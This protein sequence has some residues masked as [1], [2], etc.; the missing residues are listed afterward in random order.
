MHSYR[1]LLLALTSILCA[2]MPAVRAQH[3]API[4]S[5]I[6]WYDR[7]GHT[8][9]A[10]GGGILKDK[11]KYYLFGEYK[12]DSSNVFNGF[13]CYSSAD[14]S[15][16]TFECIALP[17]QPTGAL[18]PNRVGERPKVM[19][20]PATGEY[21]MLMHVDSVNYKDQYVGYATSSTVNGQYHF[22]GPLLFDGKPI[23]KWDI[24]VFQD[25][26][27]RG[28]LITHSGNLYRLS[29]DFHSVEEQIVKDMTPHCEAPV[30][31]RKNGFYFWLG[32][33]LTSWERN[34]NYYF[35]AT[36]LRGPWTAHGHFA[37]KGSLTWNSQ[38]TFVLPIEGPTDT[39]L[40]FMGD[41][42]AFPRQHTAATYLWLP[43]QIKADTL[44]LPRY[45]QCWQPDLQSGRWHETSLPG[46]TPATTPALT[47]QW[48]T[49]TAPD[50]QIQYAS[51]QKGDQLTLP[52]RGTRIGF[53]G[54]ASPQGGY[55]RICITNRKGEVLLR[56]GIDC[57]CNYPDYSL[58]FLSPVLPGGNYLM[59]VTVEGAHGVWRNKRGDLF[60]S[61][62]YE[63][64]LG[65]IVI[66]H[67]KSYNPTAKSTRLE[68]E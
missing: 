38:S 20:C 37:P 24:G 19:R 64:C 2:P 17:V 68:A 32:S 62:G 49:E 41:R 31:F 40:I 29:N 67:D 27:G 23:R 65:K 35:T 3:T 56:T 9:S 45:L 52:F 34:D 50:G 63:V 43:L 10:H 39:T 44:L 46:R 48:K 33:E 4:V 18:G 15:H 61:K 11:G 54:K 53:Y 30:L 28:Y 66:Q 42:W 14:L 13:S 5:G 6:P 8:V 1:L 58:R 25:K 60:G 12:S 16:W 22:R 36:S 21:V 26:D 59:T 57:Y 47:G 55:A 51:A 7:Y